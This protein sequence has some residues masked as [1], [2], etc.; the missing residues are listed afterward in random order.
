MRSARGT[1]NSILSTCKRIVPHQ[2]WRENHE[3][4]VDT[5]FVPRPRL[6]LCTL[7]FLTFRLSMG[8][9]SPENLLFGVAFRGAAT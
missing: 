1:V 6:S 2:A 9:E 4:S 7:A 3:W 8:G 5:Y